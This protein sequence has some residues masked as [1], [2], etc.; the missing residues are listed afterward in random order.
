MT[1][2]WGSL[3][4]IAA[5]REGVAA[6]KA[7]AW[8]VVTLAIAG[9]VVGYVTAKP[10]GESK[11]RMWVTT[12]ALGSN[13]SVT[14]LGIST[15]LGPQAADFLGEGILNRVE[16]STGHSYDYLIDHLTLTQPPDGGP[17]PPIALIASG[18]SEA[19]ARTLLL[20]WTTAVHQ[21][22][23]RYVSSVLSRGERGLRKGLA[24]AIVLK[25]PVTQQAIANLLARMQALRATLTVDY[26]VERRPKAYG[27]ATVSRPREAV[28]GG[29]AGLI[30]GLALA[31]L[32]SLLGGRLRTA[33][34]IE[35]AL[36][37]KL[38]ADLRSPE[39][40]PSAEHARERLRSIGGGPQPA[41]VLLVPCGGVP[42]DAA[43]RLSDALGDATQARVTGPPGEPGLLEELAR[44]DACAVVAEPGSLRRADAT[45]LRTEPRR[46]RDRLRRAGRRLIS[47][48]SPGRARSS[49]SSGRRSS[50]G[51]R[52][53]A[54]ALC[55]DGRLRRPC[56][57]RPAP[58]RS[59]A[60]ARQAHRSR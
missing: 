60:P 46:G 30:A 38:L 25:E 40:T 32:I 39:A 56:R 24:R 6:L 15:P 48:P 33:E 31:L 55:H 52:A 34:G 18:D 11:Y 20:A 17:N 14:G 4:G 10:E 9:L 43:T 51:R 5:A 44:A 53:R 35:A 37:V 45:A 36:G 12:Q 26:A 7:Y 29:G 21:A 57:G 22:R 19:A 3:T 41:T 47:A 54:P 58:T 8:I 2:D 50:R 42:S 59:P 1:A 27:E 23:L 13:G 49:G 16:A 28:V